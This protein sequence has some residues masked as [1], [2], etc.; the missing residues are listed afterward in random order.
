MKIFK[1]LSIADFVTLL[2]VVFGA[3]AVLTLM[4]GWKTGDAEAVPRACMLIL[5]GILA[6]GLDGRL[7]RY[8]RKEHVLGED[9]DSL[10]DA[11]TF[12]LAPACL[13]FVRY[14]NDFSSDNFGLFTLFLYKRIASS[15]RN[16]IRF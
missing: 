9:L 2:N 16:Y 4:Y 1:M 5:M 6:D 3:G 14:F 8:F 7:A 11:L 13:V 10:A 12:S 15:H